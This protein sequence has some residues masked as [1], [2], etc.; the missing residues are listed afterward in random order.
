MPEA[1]RAET[2]LPPEGQQR[3]LDHRALL[4]WVALH[5]QMDVAAEKCQRRLQVLGFHEHQHHVLP[6]PGGIAMALDVLG[7]DVG[8]SHGL[9]SSERE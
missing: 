6:W 7:G 3:D 9:M 5:L 2:V 8:A 1:C 4:N